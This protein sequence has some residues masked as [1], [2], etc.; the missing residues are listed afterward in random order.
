MRCS[1]YTNF[2]TTGNETIDIKNWVAET[3]T[4]ILISGV[5]FDFDET[6]GELKSFFSLLESNI[7]WKKL[8]WTCEMRQQ[9]DGKAYISFDWINGLWPQVNVAESNPQ[10]MAVKFNGNETIA[11]SFYRTVLSGGALKSYVCETRTREKKYITQLGGGYR[12]FFETNQGLML[13]TP[14]IVLDSLKRQETDLNY[15]GAMSAFE[16][17]NKEFYDYGLIGNEFKLSI[18]YNGRHLIPLMDDYLNWLIN[19]LK[20]NRTRI[21][22]NFPAQDITINNANKEITNLDIIKS[23]L[24]LRSNG[25]DAGVEIQNENLRFYEYLEALEK[26]WG[27]YFQICGLDL[28]L[29]LGS[30]QKSVA[31]VQTNYKTTYETIKNLNVFRT[32]QWNKIIREMMIAFGIDASKYEGKWTIR[33]I[34]EI[35]NNDLSNPETVMA[36]YNNRLMTKQHA[37]QTLNSSA[38]KAEIDK[39]IAELEKE[40][41]IDKQKNA[42]NLQSTENFNDNLDIEQNG[43]NTET[44]GFSFNGE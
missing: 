14:Q 25:V 26:L 32:K 35:L 33:I 42:E 15:N 44:K 43:N 12:E 24:I 3:M 20:T 10:N 16:L 2:K 38:S 17:L 41:E 22:G 28:G 27:Q 37:I 19:E 23:N 1:N 18:G 4:K 39:I 30:G 13:K 21:I 29:A 11:V 8:L 31:E 7:E 36:L 34:S 5:S 40:E 9:L 6:E